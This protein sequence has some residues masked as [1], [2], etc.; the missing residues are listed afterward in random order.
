MSTLLPVHA[1]E[2]ILAG[3]T[4]YLT[5][6]FSL[7][8]PETAKA[9]KSFLDDTE[10]GMFRGPYVRTR[11]P[12]ARATQWEDL[13]GWLP[14][15]FTPY[16]H[17]AEAFR[18][19]RSVDE[20]GER[21]PEPT[22]VITGTGSGKTEAFLYPVLAHAKRMREK[23]Q[24]GV[25]AL[26]LYPMNALANDQANRLAK[27]LTS[28][29]GLEGVSAGI[30][31]GDQNTGVTRVTEDSLI[32]DRETLRQSPPDI[33]LTNYKMLDELLL[34]PADRAIWRASATSLQYLVLDEFH[35]YDGAQGTDV[36]LL[37]RR[38]GLMLKSRQPDGFLGE[39]ADNPLGR[40]TPVATSATLGGEGDTANVLEFA[41][42][43]F[44][45]D[46]AGEAL[47][48]ETVLTFDQWRAEMVEAY[49]GGNG[50]SRSD[51][52][53]V[54]TIREVL[55]AIAGDTSGREH[56]EVVLDVV[57]TKL[58][59]AGETLEAMIAAYA[60]HPLTRALIEAAAQARPMVAR[61]G[62]ATALPAEVLGQ[63]V[64]RALKGDEATEFVT[65]LLTV[66]AHLRALAGEK[67]GFGGKRLPGVDTHLWVREVSRIDRAVTPTPDGKEFRWYDD[68]VVGEGADITADAAGAAD[69]QA[70]AVW[71]PACY[72]RACGRAGWM[73]SLE[74]G[75]EAPILDP[76]EIRKNSIEH[77]ERQRPL[78]TAI[79]ELRQATTEEVD[80]TATR[81]PEGKRT[82]MWLHTDTRAL[83]TTPPS[84]EALSRGTSVPVLTYSGQDAADYAKDQVCPSCGEPDTI[85]FIGS[86][87]A[88]LL[89]VGLSNLFGMGELDQD[90]KKTLVFADSVQDAAHR[91]GFVQS[92]SHA[93]ALRT[94]TYSV[95][96]GDTVSLAELPQ[97]IIDAAVDRAID[98]DSAA[99]AD[100]AAPSK[101]QRDRAQARARYELLPPELADTVNF[102][103]FWDFSCEA[104]AR[105]NATREAKQRLA[106]D[107]ALEFGQRAD[108][109][110]SLTLTGALNVGVDIPDAVLASVAREA[111]GGVAEQSM[112][113]GDA[114]VQLRW[115][116]GVVEQVRERGGI[117]HPWL[118]SYLR[119]DGNSWHLHNRLAKSKGVPA[120]P[121]GGAPEFPRV[122]E[123]LNDK[124]RG[125]T[126]LSSPRGRYARWTS[127]M[128]GL[129]T[130]D[131]ASVLRD[132]FAALASRNAMTS[133]QTKTG[134]TIYALEPEQVVVSSEAE[135][136]LLRCGICHAQMGVDKHA[137]TLM[138]GQAC[139]TPGCSGT[140]QEVPVEPNYYWRLYTSAQ[141]RTVVAK[142]HTSL[143]PPEERLALERAF[144]GGEAPTADAPNV[145]VATPTLEMGID[146]G[147]LS[148]VML[149]SLPTTVA[150]YV[151]RVGRAGRLTGNSL[152]LAFVRGRGPTLP[153][154]NEPLGV[155]SGA[156][157]PPAAFLSATEILHRQVA[158]YLIDSTDLPA[159]GVETSNAQ[160]VFG[161]K[162]VPLIDALHH[163]IAA[164]VGPRVDEFLGSL[165]A[166]HLPANLLTRVRDWATGQGPD[167]FA[168]ALTAAREQWDAEVQ[169]LK[170]REHDLNGIDAELKKRDAGAANLDAEFIDEDLERE[171][172]SVKA[173]LKRTKRDLH[174]LALRERWISALERYGLLPNFTLIDDSVELAVAISYLNP[175]TMEF[176][177]E[178]FE[179]ERGVSSALQELAPGATFYARGIAATI[180]SVE[181]GFDGQN[182]EQW[183]LC[184]ECS[185][186]ERV[187]SGGATPGAG[188]CPRCGAAAFADKGQL[189]D[190]IQMRKVAA[191]VDRSNAT[192]DASAEERRTTFFHT[193]MSFAVPEHAPDGGHWYLSGGFGAEYLPQADLS[194]FNLGKGQ[195]QPRMLAGREVD[196]PL[197]TL[198]RIC[199]HVDS[200]RGE[201]SKWDHRPWCPQRKER[202][203]DTVTTAL[204]RSLRT[205]G[206]LLHIPRTLTA[207]DKA[208]VPSLTAALRLGFKEVLGGDPEHLKVDTVT[209]PNPAGGG[210]IEA[211][212]LHD[213]VPGGTGY[214]SQFAS[215]EQVR[216]LFEQAYR[217]V[218]ACECHS[219]ERLACAHCLLPYTEFR[220]KDVTSRGAAERAI[221]AILRNEAHPADGADAL[222]VPWEPQT[223]P[224]APDQGSTLELRFREVLRAALEARNVTVTD[225]PN[226]GRME[227][228][229]TFPGASG[230]QWVMKEQVNK[231]H[232][233]PDFLFTHRRRGDVRPVAVY[234]DGYAYHA[235]QAHFRFPQDMIKRATLHFEDD[236]IPWNLT[237]A[238]LDR[239]ER[240]GADAA[241]PWWVTAELR[242]TISGLPKLDSDAVDFLL[243][244]PM[245][246]LLRYLKAPR[247]ATFPAL[248]RGLAELVLGAPGRQQSVVDSMVRVALPS[249]ACLDLRPIS[250]TEFAPER[251]FMDTSAGVLEADAWNEYLRMANVLWLAG[252]GVRV[253]TSAGGVEK[254]TLP[255][256]PA[257]QVAGA[258]A[259]AI[260]EFED[261]EAVVAALRTL[262]A[263]HAAPASEIGEELGSLPTA[264]IW[265]EAKVALLLEADPSYAEAEADLVRGG[266]TIVHPEGLT[267]D[268][269]PQAL[270]GN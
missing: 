17:Q 199:G 41:R 89:S 239:F 214:L 263:Q 52:P 219:D 206:V 209:V 114:D 32:T 129:S 139:A 14:S 246:Q 143:V 197:F 176:M 269:I 207:G 51:M 177:P 103:P 13:L 119:D 196:A 117:N 22:L 167:S 128:L 131:S 97:R 3:V 133:V 84:E 248:G 78:I 151:Q 240:E 105:R 149:A 54:E 18:R 173:A 109:A 75:T 178:S 205:Q 79:N 270:L 216:G 12:Y 92:R 63:T 31:V 157:A 8:N 57:R 132:F 251:L 50:A 220:H 123:S 215:P 1:S 53:G 200:A 236:T 93:F 181:M 62:E 81:D 249:G 108:L 210:V 179:V 87:V 257:P 268:A 238:D 67:Y 112:T 82:P 265:R 37:L 228:E 253:E 9:L 27:L 201:N 172:R 193:A 223:T 153:K 247:T 30:Y 24:R 4:E 241:A 73:T 264:L 134:G 58:W 161:R 11:L 110:R 56:A 59:G 45:E 156:V 25:K 175:T 6:T 107:T 115:A 135:P 42:T 122:G 138:N 48:G 65:H 96:G 144:R 125:I 70:P 145:L 28:E 29:P 80:F 66:V 203:E 190:V 55:D 102:R 170:Q 186:G 111:V 60:Q 147:D 158:A 101:A 160:S 225:R 141:P 168:G 150:N 124:D 267:P 189:M 46:F 99:G 227:L 69:E 91:A 260:E 164:G 259:E 121:R 169:Q 154:L 68:G 118:K 218:A 202:D 39:Y 85:R 38:L 94:F 229:I 163:I 237:D 192:I 213:S 64:I 266:W 198:C 232:T 36:A 155:I 95:V 90:E 183:R 7:A 140:Y 61:A 34:R 152:V 244:S 49:G 43:I 231:G 224:P 137:R 20:A 255:A 100:G 16:H 184:P 235:S 250:P 233:V 252:Q 180:D 261:E 136:K 113:S 182:I 148:T 194:W 217:R 256:E 19:L 208:T 245:E 44:G 195:A 33:L 74:P 159:L 146:I 120:F 162:G 88:T 104:Q 5:T 171:K 76:A 26:L 130:H 188:P 165:T 10:T 23:G 204:G 83:S 86:R 185:Y 47:I 77:R 226:A 72:C 211:L 258:W 106:F 116:R 15:W 142:E 21:R 40:V 230:E 126:P 127:T 242:R 187:A 191:E 35:T 262:A 234:T 2:H 174:E 221:R 212:L 98:A 254:R 243:A 166:E 222:A 71:L